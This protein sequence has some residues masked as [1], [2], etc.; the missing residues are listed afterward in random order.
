MD[1]FNKEIKMD[2]MMRKRDLNNVPESDRKFQNDYLKKVQLT[3]NRYGLYYN[4][5]N[6]NTLNGL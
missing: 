5:Y 4:Q 1:E 2:F 6:D 3:L